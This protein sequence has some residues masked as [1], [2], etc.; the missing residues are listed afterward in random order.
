MPSTYYIYI[1]MWA[2]PQQMGRETGCCMPRGIVLG[3]GDLQAIRDEQPIGTILWLTK[4]HSA[5]TWFE[6]C[7]RSVCGFTGEIVCMCASLAA[8]CP[9]TQS[10]SG[11]LQLLDRSFVLL[12]YSM[13]FQRQTLL[14]RSLLRNSERPN[15]CGQT[16]F[17][18]YHDARQSSPVA[19]E[20]QAT[21]I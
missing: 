14:Q 20:S 8:A 2:T 18:S 5:E 1:Q 4:M 7:V 16:R 10:I 11:C 6:G 3:C 9:T 21:C 19:S 12:P 17:R 13:S 15:A